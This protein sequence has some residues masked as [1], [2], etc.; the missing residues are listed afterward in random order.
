MK[1]IINR[2]LYEG[3]DENLKG[4]VIDIFHIKLV[5]PPMNQKYTWMYIKLLCCIESHTNAS[6][7]THNK[8]LDEGIDA[9]NVFSDQE[10]EEISLRFGK[11][12]QEEIMKFV[13][14]LLKAKPYGI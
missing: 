1:A 4:A 12:S 7:D 2:D 8:L 10:C 3:G 9:E 11:Y 6:K 14:T 13:E 5:S